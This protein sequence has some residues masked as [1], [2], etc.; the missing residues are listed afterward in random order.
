VTARDPNIEQDVRAIVQRIVDGLMD[1]EPPTGA[2]VP[3]ERSDTTESGETATARIAIGADHGGY[4]MK[5]RLGFKLKEQGYAVID[6]GTDSVE[7]VDYPD[8][9]VA[10][11]RRV[12]EG[13]A[14]VGIMVDGAGIGSSMAANK[15]QGVR[16]ALCYDV[17]TAH[18]AREHNHANV[19]TL[20]AGLIGDSLAWQI[21]EAFLATPYGGGRHARRVDKINDLDRVRDSVS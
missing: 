6:C 10:V 15:V 18:N 19:L 21:A 8:F 16:A 17:S 1:G 20:G 7:P 12:A 4:A 3:H 9:A 11:A 13:S 14:D 5:E 2:D